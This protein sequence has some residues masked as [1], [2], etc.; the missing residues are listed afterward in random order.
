M[1]EEILMKLFLLPCKF[2]FKFAIPYLSISDIIL[3]NW[4]VFS[5]AALPVVIGALYL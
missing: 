5:S 1:K 3:Q 4:L 2:M